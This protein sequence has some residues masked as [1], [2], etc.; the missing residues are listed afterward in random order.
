[1]LPRPGSASLGAIP[2]N[3]SEALAAAEAMQERARLL[4]RLSAEHLR[5]LAR[6][7]FAAGWTPA[8]LLHALDHD[9]RGRQHGYSAG[10]RSPAGWVRSRLAAWLGPDAVPLP[11]RSQRVAEARRQVL[12]EQAARRQARQVAAHRAARVDVG[13]RVAELR[14][15]VAAVRLRQTSAPC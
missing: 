1:M 4:G 10:V 6:P 3:G 11:S 14:A 2:Q 8:D 9:T 12:A 15:I 7:F 13:A 5:H